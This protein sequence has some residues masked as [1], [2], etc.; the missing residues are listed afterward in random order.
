MTDD[1]LSPALP[2]H[3]SAYQDSRSTAMKYYSPTTRQR[4]SCHRRGECSGHCRTGQKR[5]CTKSSMPVAP[6]HNTCRK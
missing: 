4:G 5:S 6:V 1:S 2:D 3:A